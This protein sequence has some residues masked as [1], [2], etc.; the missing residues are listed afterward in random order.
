MFRLQKAGGS[1]YSVSKQRYR[2]DR[3]LMPW[4][5]GMLSAVALDRCVLWLARYF[6][7]LPACQKKSC[8][9]GRHLNSF[10]TS[11]KKCLFPA[12]GLYAFA[13][14]AAKNL[15]NSCILIYFQVTL[16]LKYEE[17]GWCK[18]KRKIGRAHV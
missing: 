8:V 1:K 17:G 11:W 4:H 15:E 13:Y 3:H 14:S 6:H 18:M 16:F 10:S 5:C 7:E 12:F 9:S 2:T